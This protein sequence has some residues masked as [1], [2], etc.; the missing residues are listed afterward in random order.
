M[1]YVHLN[2]G[3]RIEIPVHYDMWM[4]GARFGTITSYRS[5]GN[6]RS[7]YYNVKL[8]HPSVRRRLKLWLPDVPY[9]RILPSESR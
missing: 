4:Q 5:G 9:A 1:E 3:T 2:L 8:D 7:A 6:G